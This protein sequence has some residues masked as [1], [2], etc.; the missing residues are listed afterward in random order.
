MDE[1][2]Q[3][4][5]N[6]WPEELQ[7]KIIKHMVTKTGWHNIFIECPHC[8]QISYREYWGRE[9]HY[10]LHCFKEFWVE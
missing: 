4:V 9:W 2:N 3:R 1:E 7:G 10:C 8:K 6:E 5:M